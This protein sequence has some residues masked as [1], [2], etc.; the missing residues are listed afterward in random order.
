MPKFILHTSG[1]QYTTR[2]GSHR[3]DMA[4]LRQ[5]VVAAAEALERMGFVGEAEVL[6]ADDAGTTILAASQ[7]F[8][9]LI[10][11]QT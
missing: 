9:A 6:I 5:L 11:D 7:T 8:G 4:L 1:R 2:D 3:D 10:T